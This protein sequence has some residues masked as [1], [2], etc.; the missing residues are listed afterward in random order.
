MTESRVADRIR[1]IELRS[2]AAGPDRAAGPEPT[3]PSPTSAATSC[4]PCKRRGSRARPHAITKSVDVPVCLLGRRCIPC[5]YTFPAHSARVD[6]LR[7][8]P[9]SSPA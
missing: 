1:R 9:D 3:G 6:C 2:D 8:Q 4:S 7:S 5:G